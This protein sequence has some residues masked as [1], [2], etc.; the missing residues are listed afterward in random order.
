MTTSKKHANAQ[1]LMRKREYSRKLKELRK[2]GAYEPKGDELT[3]YRIK[4]IN[5][6]W[7]AVEEFIAPPPGS[8]KEFFFVSA[9]KLTNK[10]RRDFI[11]NAASLDIPHTP[12]GVFLQKEGQ[13]KARLAWNK[14]N[15]EYDILLTGK[16]KW[17]E[18]KGKAISDRI[19]IGPV[20]RITGELQR[21]E[22]VA[23][24]FEPLGKGEALSFVVIEHGEEV[25]ASI[26]TFSSPG[27][28]EKLRDYID[29]RYH[30]DN[31]AARLKFLRM[32][33]V[34]KTTLIK[35]QPTYNVSKK[36]SAQKKAVGYRPK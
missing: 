20:D 29:T 34:R 9:D 15:Q 19:P 28:A 31:K 6:A 26:S 10:E 7:A 1:A 23:K 5:K 32:I 21:I 17:G 22:N 4:R 24:T 11:G 35:G 14:D 18:N 8:N 33:K 13:R 16:V 30:R 25:G 36:K 2:V 27:A 12:K 3:P